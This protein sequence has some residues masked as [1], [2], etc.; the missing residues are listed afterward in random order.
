[1][2]FPSGTIG[3]VG[4]GPVEEDSPGP[5]SLCGT[6]VRFN[7]WSRRHS[8]SSENIRNGGRKADIVFT[9]GDS[10]AHRYGTLYQLPKTI[11][12]IRKPGNLQA[13]IDKWYRPWNE[14]LIISDDDRKACN[15]DLETTWATAGGTALWLLDRYASGPFYVCGFTWEIERQDRKHNGHSWDNERL[16]VKKTL[17]PQPRWTFSGR[18]GR[19]LS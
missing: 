8:P 9:N 2:R 6:I 13:T 4:N 16:W 3:I 11:V 7:D 17:L 19:A 12:F 18:T 15:R 1:M 10:H 14:K 5:L